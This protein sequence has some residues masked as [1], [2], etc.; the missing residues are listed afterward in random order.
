MCYSLLRFNK[1]KLWIIFFVMSIFSRCIH[2][3]INTLMKVDGQD[4]ALQHI[5]VKTGSHSLP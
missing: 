4:Q 2:I 3:M 1:I 5:K